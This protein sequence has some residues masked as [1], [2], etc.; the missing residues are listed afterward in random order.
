MLVGYEIL[1]Q[2]VAY[3]NQWRSV[4]TY[5]FVEEGPITRLSK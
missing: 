2:V 1:Q 5:E 4:G 3:V